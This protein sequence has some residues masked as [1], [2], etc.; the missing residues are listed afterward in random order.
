M[1]LL[2]HLRGRRL[3]LQKPCAKFCGRNFFQTFQKHPFEL[4]Q[5]GRSNRNDL[6]RR[7]PVDPRRETPKTRACKNSAI[8]KLSSLFIRASTLRRA[9]RLDAHPNARASI[10]LPFGNYYLNSWL[11]EK[12]WKKRIRNRTQALK[13]SIIR[14]LCIYPF[15]AI[16]IVQPEAVCERAAVCYLPET[17]QKTIQSPVTNLTVCHRKS[18][19]GE[20]L[21]ERHCGWTSNITLSSKYLSEYISNVAL[22]MPLDIGSVRLFIFNRRWN[23][24]SNF[25]I[26]KNKNN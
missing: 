25:S 26:N 23:C 12:I 10:E 11:N 2:H 24:Y 20:I 1:K 4:L 22:N 6:D 9:L 19:R 21:S 8:I 14:T 16:L 18:H 13:Q 7:S 3:P 5:H 17:I 15:N